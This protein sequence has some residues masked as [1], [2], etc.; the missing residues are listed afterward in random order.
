MFTYITRLP[1]GHVFAIANDALLAGQFSAARVALETLATRDDHVDALCIPT[2]YP[3]VAALPLF[4]YNVIA[5]R[6]RAADSRAARN[7]STSPTGA[8]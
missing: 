7:I 6:I 2:A 1:T 3:R 4:Y 5:D 8:L